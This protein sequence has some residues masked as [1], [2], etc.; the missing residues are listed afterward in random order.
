MARLIDLIRKDASAAE[1]RLP[2]WRRRGLFGYVRIRQ[3]DS[4]RP[5]AGVIG[6]VRPLATA[7][8]FRS[9]WRD[10]GSVDEAHSPRFPRTAVPSRPAA[11]LRRASPRRRAARGPPAAASATRYNAV[12]HRISWHAQ[13]MTVPVPFRIR[14][15]LHHWRPGSSQSAMYRATWRRYQPRREGVAAVADDAPWPSVSLRWRNGAAPPGQ[16]SSAASSIV[17]VRRRHPRVRRAPVALGDR[18]PLRT[19]HHST[20]ALTHACGGWWITPRLIL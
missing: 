1:H 20:D 18:S 12:Q 13:L 4:G 5:C 3:T 10:A 15:R 11:I 9:W 2:H 8:F 6:G 17:A 16:P 19:A 7:D 14:V